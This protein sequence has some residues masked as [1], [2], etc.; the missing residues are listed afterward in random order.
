MSLVEVSLPDGRIHEIA[1]GVTA[2]EV[3]KDA[4]GRGAVAAI[5]NGAPCD[6]LTT[7]EESCTLDQIHSESEDGLHVLRH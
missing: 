3:I 6:L 4:F 2:A 5:I 1:V 7:I